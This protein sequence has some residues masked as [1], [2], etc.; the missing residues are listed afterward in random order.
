KRPFS[1]RKGELEFRP[2]H[3]LDRDGD[4][5]WSPYDKEF[6]SYNAILAMCDRR[7]DRISVDY[8]YS[9]DESESIFATALVKLFHPV[10]VYGEHERNIK[11]GKSVETVIGFMYEPQCWSLNVSYTDDRAMDTQ[12]YFVEVSL[13]GLG[14]IGL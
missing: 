7:G 4:A 5:S 2:H 12:E 10:S 6:Q 11:D 8:L 9:R 14:K 1:D 13:Y 3:C